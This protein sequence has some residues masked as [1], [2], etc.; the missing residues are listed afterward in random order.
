M[1]TEKQID[2]AMKK[3]CLNGMKMNLTELECLLMYLSL[4]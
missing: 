2:E 4:K 3:L 1:V